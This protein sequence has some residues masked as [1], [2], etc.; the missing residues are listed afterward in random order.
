M[1]F[2]CVDRNDRTQEN[3]QTDVKLQRNGFQENYILNEE[4]IFWCLI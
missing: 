3:K 1:Q 2:F 4:V